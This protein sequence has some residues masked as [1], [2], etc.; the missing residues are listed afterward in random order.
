MAYSIKSKERSYVKDKDMK[1]SKFARW[2]VKYIIKTP[3]VFY[4]FCPGNSFVLIL[5]LSLKMDIMQ[6][7]KAHVS[8]REVVLDGEYDILSDELYL[9]RNRN[10]EVFRLLIEGWEKTGGGTVCTVEDGKSLSGN[11]N[12]D[13]VTGSQTLLEKIFAGMGGRG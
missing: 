13:I 11:M 9:Y 7:A 2:Y 10:E 6:T 12:A 3:L 4:L 1:K 5:S 8:G